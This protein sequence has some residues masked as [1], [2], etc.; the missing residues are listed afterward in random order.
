MAQKI[1]FLPRL[2]LLSPFKNL[3]LTKKVSQSFP[4]IYQP[5]IIKYFKR[6]QRFS[7]FK[8]TQQQ[9]ILHILHTIFHI[10]NS[11]KSN[12]FPHFLLS[13]NPKQESNK[14]HVNLS[15]T[16]YQNLCNNFT[17]IFRKIM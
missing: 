8:F 14:K 17:K 5:H 13:K 10:F 4:P 15:Q 12:Y 2:Q 3:F 11:R 1:N 9:T 7:S 6:L 16:I